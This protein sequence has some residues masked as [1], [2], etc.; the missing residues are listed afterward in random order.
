MTL[1][2]TAQYGLMAVPGLRRCRVGAPLILSTLIRLSS[3]MLLQEALVRALADA[4]RMPEPLPVMNNGQWT[5]FK[6]DAPIVFDRHESTTVI[7]WFNGLDQEAYKL[8]REARREKGHILCPHGK[9]RATNW[10]FRH[11]SPIHRWRCLTLEQITS[12]T[13]RLNTRTGPAS[14]VFPK[15]RVRQARNR[16]TRVKPNTRDHGATGCASGS[17]EGCPPSSDFPADWIAKPVI[18]GISH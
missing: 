15:C 8:S 10:G 1:V 9:V 16:L 18:P 14:H 2:S 7:E 4:M 12:T 3:N 5:R 13:H 11:G 6:N 17:S